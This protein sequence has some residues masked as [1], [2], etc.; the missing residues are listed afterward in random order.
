MNSRAAAA[1]VIGVFAWAVPA[2]RAQVVS[3][4]Q[5]GNFTY[6][7]ADPV[8]GAPITSLIV[9]PTGTKVAVY[10]VQTGGNIQYTNGGTTTTYNNVFSQLGVEGLAVRLVYNGN[11]ARVPNNT[12][13][14]TNSNIITNPNFDFI[15]KGG[16]TATPPSGNSANNTLDTS[17]N[18]AVTEGILNFPAPVYPGAEDPMANTSRILI[19]S[20]ILQA[21]APGTEQLTAEDPFA[22]GN[23]ILT[24]TVPPGGTPDGFHGEQPLDRF[25]TQYAASPTYPTLNVTAVPEPGTLILGGLAVIG[26]VGRFRRRRD[27]TD[28]VTTAV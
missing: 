25:L 5:P 7:F 9:G 20:F 2:A 14:N 24:G 23:Q 22:V 4:F 28:G 26:L 10:L 1:I 27:R 19:G 11:V 13:T 17:T 8:T 18:A 21:T 16:S 6:Q 3:N 12:N 15:T